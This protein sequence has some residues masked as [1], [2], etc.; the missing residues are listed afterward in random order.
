MSQIA[1]TFTA[2]LGNPDMMDLLATVAT[3]AIA[4]GAFQFTRKTGI[5][6]EEKHRAALHSALMTGIRAAIVA[7]LGKEAAV[8]AAVRYASRSVPDAIA[9]LRPGA[10]VTAEIAA[11]KYEQARNESLEP[12][13]DLGIPVFRP[14]SR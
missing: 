10:D 5:E 8:L 4:W 13:P 14:R 9:K 2:V 3:S 7:G 6:V 11:A 1:E 12:E